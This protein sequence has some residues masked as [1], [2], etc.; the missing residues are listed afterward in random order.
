LFL[1]TVSLPVGVQ[2]GKSLSF[3]FMH[4]KRRGVVFNNGVIVNNVSFKYTFSVQSVSSLSGELVEESSPGSNSRLF[5]GLIGS[6]LSFDLTSKFSENSQN[7]ANSISRSSRYGHFQERFDHWAKS[8]KLFEMIEIFEIL[9]D[10]FNF[11]FELDER[12]SL[13]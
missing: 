6:L 11:G 2:N 8:V 3:I 1:V 13:M 9:S 7:L 10:F 5:K 4:G 12:S